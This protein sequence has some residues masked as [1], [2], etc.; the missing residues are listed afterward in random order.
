LS[1]AASACYFDAG[2]VEYVDMPL[3]G[4][5][6]L[7]C[8][9]S[10][11]YLVQDGE[12]SLAVLLSNQRYTYPPKITVEIMGGE[13][14]A[15]ERFIRQLPRQT[16]HGKA[17]RGHIL[18]LQQ[19]CHRQM[20]VQFHHLPPIRREELILPEALLKRI[21]RH[22]LS[23]IR[24]AERLRAAGRH[25]KRGILLHGPPGTGK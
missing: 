9:K 4:E 2:P 15:A 1:R 23:F 18:S 7:A 8:V 20:S 17:Y 21:E 14:E 10:G 6:H 19:D 22:T 24:H 13:R 25:L 16:R 3:P 11:L 12:Q 5:Q